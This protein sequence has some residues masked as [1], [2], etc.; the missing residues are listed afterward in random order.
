MVCLVL[1]K[2]MVQ[3]LCSL[4]RVAGWASVM[5]DTGVCDEGDYTHNAVDECN[6][7]LAPTIFRKHCEVHAFH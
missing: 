6:R 1:L 3:R 4:S 7:D 2:C 5:L